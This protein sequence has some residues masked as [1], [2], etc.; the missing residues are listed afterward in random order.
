MAWR[1][2]VV[3]IQTGRKGIPG[4]RGQLDIAKAV[5]RRWSCIGTRIWLEQRKGEGHSGKQKK[6]VG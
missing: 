6:K 3:W 2:G 5:G 1:I 4:R